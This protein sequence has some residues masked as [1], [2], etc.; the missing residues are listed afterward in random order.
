LI[1]KII[2]V[3]TFLKLTMKK[4]L[5]SLSVFAAFAANAQMDTLSAHCMIATTYTGMIDNVAPIDSGFIAGSNF[6]GDLAKMQLFDGTHGVTGGGTIKGIALPCILKSGTGNMT[7]AIWADNA[8][9]PNY[10][11]PLASKV[12]ALT[13]I[14]TAAASMMALGDGN[15]YNNV[16]TFT[17][18]VAIPANGKFWA[19]FILPTGA[20]A[21]ATAISTPFADGATHT[22]EIQGSGTFF[23]FD[24]GTN[25]T[26]QLD[27][28]ITVY[29]IVDFTLGLNE[30][31]ISSSV[32]PNPANAELN[33]KTTED[34]TSVV[35]TTTDGKTV[36][37]GTTS[38]INVAALNAGM[39]IYQVTTVSGKV[40][41]GNFVKN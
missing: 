1:K 7:F 33:I 29:P 35:V 41:T 22:G 8:G 13:A 23:T 40:G 19:G 3:Q 26:W 10:A 38:N 28:A 6:Y 18:P 11:T 4:L 37:T 36:A 5:L 2:F 14:D 24:D 31:V 27:A 9:V 32:Y 16:I 21:F 39:Y 34:I 20:N 12:V 30:N 15:I 25:A 17:T